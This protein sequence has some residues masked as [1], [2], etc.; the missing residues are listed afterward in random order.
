MRFPT[1]YETKNSVYSVTCH[2]F[3]S[4]IYLTASF[5]P[6]EIIL[7]KTHESVSEKIVTNLSICMH[8]Y[9]L[10]LIYLPTLHYCDQS[11]S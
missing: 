3:I 4:N 1:S 11:L 9:L 8:F 6:Y 10:I 5:R 2:G 7:L